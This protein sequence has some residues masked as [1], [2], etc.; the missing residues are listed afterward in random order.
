MG[1]LLMKLSQSNFDLRSPDC[2][3]VCSYLIATVFTKTVA[4]TAFWFHSNCT[5]W[6]HMYIYEVNKY[7]LLIFPFF[8]RDQEKITFIFLHVLMTNDY[9]SYVHHSPDVLWVL[10]NYV[11]AIIWIIWNMNWGNSICK[12]CSKKNKTR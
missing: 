6:W 7:M 2:Y 12:L 3:L 11:V 4:H 5:S 1:S 10:W 8:K 9:T